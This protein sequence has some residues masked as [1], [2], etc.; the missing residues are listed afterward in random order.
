[1]SSETQSIDEYFSQMKDIIQNI[2]KKFNAALPYIRKQAN[3]AIQSHI[4][5]SFFKTEY[6][7]IFDSKVNP[8]TYH[9]NLEKESQT[10]IRSQRYIYEWNHY[11]DEILKHNK[12]KEF[13]E[14]MKQ[15]YMMV[16]DLSFEETQ[17]QKFRMTCLKGFVALLCAIRIQ[18]SSNPS[19]NSILD[20]IKLIQQ[21]TQIKLTDVSMKEKKRFKK[22]KR[23]QTTSEQA[24]SV[25]QTVQSKAPLLPEQNQLPIKPIKV[26]SATT[27]QL[28]QVPKSQQAPSESSISTLQQQQQQSQAQQQPQQ[29]Q[30][31]AQ[32]QQV[33]QQALQ[34]Q[35]QLPQQQLQLLQQLFQLQQPQKDTMFEKQIAQNQ[36]FILQW[37]LTRQLLQPKLNILNLQCDSQKLIYFQD[38]ICKIGNYIQVPHQNEHNQSNQRYLLLEYAPLFS[39]FTIKR[40]S[41]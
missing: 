18:F 26:S 15:I 21:Q 33:T 19:C 36:Q 2:L 16:L 30:Q 9:S 3:G 6:I 34:Q 40:E 11:Q 8:N 13:L 28:Q 41:Q 27:Q 17:S 10:K 25:V 22:Q 24:K 35:Q 20:L 38:S 1:M 4:K 39:F 31:P 32:S 7:K 37:E 14:R 12:L 23:V 29:Q 5:T